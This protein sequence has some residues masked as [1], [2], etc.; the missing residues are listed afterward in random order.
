MSTLFI[1]KFVNFFIFSFYV[2]LTGILDRIM[3]KNNELLY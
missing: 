1:L 2:I 3:T